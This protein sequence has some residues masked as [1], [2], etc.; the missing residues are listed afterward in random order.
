MIRRRSLPLVLTLA[1]LAGALAQS[2]DPLQA[3]IAAIERRD[4]AAAQAN[5]EEATRRAPNDASAWLWLA[6]TCAERK[7][8]DAAL[9]AAGKA[10][11]LGMEDPTILQRL[12]NFYS[13]PIPDP[14][15]AAGLGARYAERRPE[16]KTAWRRLAVFCLA[17]G[18]PDRAIE[19]A[20]R[21]MAGDNSAELHGLLGRAYGERG[22]WSQAASELAE[23]VKLSPYDEDARFR[24]AQVY[25]LQPDFVSATR[26]LEDAR[27][28]F[29]KSPQIELALG[30]AYYGQRDFPKAVDQ[31]LKTIRLAPDVLPP[32][33]F[34][35]RILEHTGDRLPEVAERF[36]ELE[37]RSPQNAM[38][39]LL[40]AK[41]IM[42]R[43]APGGYPP[44]AQAAL[45]LL[46]RA[47]SLKEDDAEAHYLIGTLLE[48]KGEIGDAA[49]HLER[50]IALN[51][52]DPAPHYRLA[53]VYARL[54]RTEESG[55]QRELHVRLSEEEG[56]AP[57]RGIVIEPPRKLPPGK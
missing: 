46:Q 11:A 27:K 13:G 37:A 10:E 17:T 1:G 25:L 48:R 56:A 49:A 41:G 30:V 29:D 45:E 14:V 18:Q 3:G 33:V 24:L 32:Y 55:K 53:R 9:R 43:M 19:A 57:S 8:T 38:A 22:Q 12:V 39:C 15:K 47:L 42:A 40:R 23:A 50:S 54:G 2:R 34:L 35:G 4:L 6:V 20:T 31:F 5:F 36:A 16:D 28:V 21:G 44:E 26:V 7:D 51:P 52:K